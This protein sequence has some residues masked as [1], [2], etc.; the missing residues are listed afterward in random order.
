M[1]FSGRSEYV[2]RL[3]LEQ[4]NKYCIKTKYMLLSQSN[5]LFS[6]IFAAIFFIV[7]LLVLKLSFEGQSKYT[8]ALSMSYLALGGY[9]TLVLPYQIYEVHAFALESIAS[10]ALDRTE[11][12]GNAASASRMSSYKSG[13]STRSPTHD[14]DQNL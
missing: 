3:S 7:S 5:T 4:T 11:K 13:V 8:I 1:L 10:D 12:S 6:Y 9:R 2:E 14:S